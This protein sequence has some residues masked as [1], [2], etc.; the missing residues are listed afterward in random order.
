M[1]DIVF[2]L[3]DLYTGAMSLLTAKAKRQAPPE[4]VLAEVVDAGALC[5]GKD[6]NHHDK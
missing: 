3:R 2:S 5:S 1:K 6:T 4:S